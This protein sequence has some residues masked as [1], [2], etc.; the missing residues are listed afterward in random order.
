M[1]NFVKRTRN[2]VRHNE[3][4]AIIATVRKIQTLTNA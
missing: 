1:G 4:T 3:K 2:P